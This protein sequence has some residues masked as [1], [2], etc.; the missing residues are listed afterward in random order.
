[1][2]HHLRISVLALSLALGAGALI[3]ADNANAFERHRSGAWQNSRDGSGTVQRDSVRTRKTLDRNTN[4]TNAN[5]GSGSSQLHRERDPQAGTWASNRSVTN[6]RGQTATWNKSGQK[7]ETGAT[8]HGEGSN[9]RGQ[10][11]SMDRSITNNGDGTHSVDST[12]TNETT[13][14]SLSTDKTISK[15][16]T[17]YASSGSYTTSGGQSGTTSG[18]LTRT[19]DGYTRSSS[20][21]SSGGQTASKD[22]EVIV[23]E[24]SATRSVTTTGLNGQTNTRSAT[25]TPDQN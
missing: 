18:S 24:G 21:T 16:E 9:F 5:G 7:T 10:E 4:W 20:L 19:E 6:A 25:Y 3:P 12:W 15:T 13:G 2:N 22:V 14:K 8:V 23:E 17:G 11:V 1:M